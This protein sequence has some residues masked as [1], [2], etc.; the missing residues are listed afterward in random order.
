MNSLSFIF[1]EPLALRLLLLYH[2]EEIT[3]PALVYLFPCYFRTRWQELTS[4]TDILLAQ[5]LL[6]YQQKSDPPVDLK[7]LITHQ[8]FCV[9]TGGKRPNPGKRSL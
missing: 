8:E 9:S 2:L 5:D 4:I 7:K 6:F 1:E 3:V